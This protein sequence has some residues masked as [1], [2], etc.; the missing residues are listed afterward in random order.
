MAT[1]RPAYRPPAAPGSHRLPPHVYWRRR[2]IVS[3]ALVTVV[4]LGYLGVTLGFALVN[5]ALGGSFQARFAEWGRQHGMGTVVT[6]I[7]T[8]YY[9]LHPPR[10]GGAPNKGSFGNGGTNVTV[11]KSTLY[12]P[13][14]TTIPSPAGTPLPGEG[15][16]HA[17]GRLT[18]T[19]VPAVYEAFVRPDAIHTSYVVGVAWMD[20]RVL[21][22]QL[23]SGSFIPGVGMPFKYTAPIGAVAS[24]SLVAAFNAG[25]RMQDA[26]GGYYTDGR[27]LIH[28]RTGAASVVI[29]KNGT[30]TV[31]R[32]NPSMMT[33]E[34]A[35]VRQNLDLIVD[36]GHPVAGLGAANAIKWGKTL[37]GTFN[38][39]RSGLGVTKNGAIVY[40]GG[41]AMSISDLANVEARAGVVTG[42][43]LDI[44][45]DWVQ[46]AT[47]TGPLG[48]AIN[49]SAG[50]NLLGGMTYAPT[51]FFASW[52]SRDFFTM[53]LRPPF[54]PGGSA[55]TTTTTT[56]HG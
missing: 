14:P 56:G 38:V 8:E 46:Y 52:M 44:N 25:F 32:W 21:R 54:L 28:L 23:Y 36:N 27:T 30:M 16:W 2:A 55:S 19:G 29:Y 50:K 47:Y 41:P 33:N 37:G 7:E 4:V 42:M 11:P 6:W 39:W 48:R 5:P 43:E 34:I 3:L 15:V 20:P 1:T 53:S 51:R 49:G 17:S 45:T 40:V 13:A 31:A 22:A 12:L 10:Q 35:S 26:N 9:K 18:A 24:R